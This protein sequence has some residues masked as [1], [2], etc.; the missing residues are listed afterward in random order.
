MKIKIYQIDPKRDDK[1]LIFRPYAKAVEMSKDGKI[2]SDI[3]DKVFEGEVDAETLDEVYYIFNNEHPENYTGRS[4]SILDVV[5]VVE[6]KAE[7]PGFYFCDSV[8]FKLGNFDP[9]KTLDKTKNETLTVLKVSP[10]KAPEVITIA[11]GLESL[12]AQVKGDIEQFSCFD[13][14]C[15]IICNE[16]GKLE[17]LELNRAVY[18]EED[19]EVSYRELKELFREAE[20][21]NGA[22]I[23]GYVVFSQDN[24]DAQYSE[25]SRSYAISSNN[26]AFQSKMGGYSIYGSA[27][28][29]SDDNVRLDR[30]MYDEHGG[31]NGWT[32][33][34]C[35]V[36]Q[37]TTE[38]MDIMAGD[39]LVVSAPITSED[40][41]S[42]NE[43]Q[44]KKYSAMFRYPERFVKINGAVVAIPF[45]PDRPKNNMASAR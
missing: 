1:D 36:S 12:Q 33:E 20:E 30:F 7:K 37:R 29:G 22:H 44:I 6:S 14:E 2:R 3:F 24:F 5:E 25:D 19:V 43:Q 4:L 8:G 45:D 18:S 34:K 11:K 35:Y 23:T 39:F 42:L 9:D 10:G 38:I 21:N 15:V 17:G 40:Y 31:P 13:D 26:K 16:N 41:E 28:D 32:I 27:L